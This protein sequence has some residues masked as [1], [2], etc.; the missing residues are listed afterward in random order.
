MALKKTKTFESFYCNN[1]WFCSKRC[2]G[3]VINNLLSLLPDAPN[4][5][6]VCYTL[7]EKFFGRMSA[8]ILQL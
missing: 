7:P 8:S 2:S 3:E 5:V 1:L 6:V 4:K